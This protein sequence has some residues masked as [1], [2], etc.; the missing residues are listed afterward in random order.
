MDSSGCRPRGL[1]L[2]CGLSIRRDDLGHLHPLADQVLRQFEVDRIRHQRH[3][4]ILGI[5][6]EDAAQVLVALLGVGLAIHDVHQP[7]GHVLSL[8]GRDEV[9]EHH[10][11]GCVP[12]PYRSR[13][14]FTWMR[15]FSPYEFAGRLNHEEDRDRAILS[16]RRRRRRFGCALPRNPGSAGRCTCRVGPARPSRCGH[17]TAG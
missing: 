14:D 4:G 3:E 11:C 12:Y 5:I 8:L 10:E 6:I 2:M 16:R 13:L 17:P 15:F 1:C 7:V 9:M